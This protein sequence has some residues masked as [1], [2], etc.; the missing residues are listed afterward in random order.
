MHLEN[1]LIKWYLS[2][3]QP[4]Y[5]KLKVYINKEGILL[6]ELNQ[7]RKFLMNI[8]KEIN[9]IFGLKFIKLNITN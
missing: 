3:L 7:L 6:K 2:N 5:F 9:K 4:F 8:K 1:T